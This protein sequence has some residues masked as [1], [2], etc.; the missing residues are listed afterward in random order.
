MKRLKK[1]KNNL[2][3]YEK[4]RINKHKNKQIKKYQ[5]VPNIFNINS[6]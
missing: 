5:Y 4:R 6:L 3:N 2:K 1:Q